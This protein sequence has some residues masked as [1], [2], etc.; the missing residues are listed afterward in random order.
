MGEMQLHFMAIWKEVDLLGSNS[1]WPKGTE[2]KGCPASL[3]KNRPPHWDSRA[4]PLLVPRGPHRMAKG[5]C[6]RGVV[7]LSAQTPCS[8]QDASCPDGRRRGA[9]RGTQT[10]WVSRNWGLSVP[11]PGDQDSRARAPATF[12]K[13]TSEGPQH[14]GEGGP[15]GGKG[16]SPEERAENGGIFRE[17]GNERT[18]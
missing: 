5:G 6:S 3:F 1:R 15:T 13:I 8:A 4:P 17:T 7:V 18:D 14:R 9:G 2:A 12:R 10:S 16:D 11:R